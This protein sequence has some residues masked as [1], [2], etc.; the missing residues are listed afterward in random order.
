[1]FELTL[2]GHFFLNRCE[3]WQPSPLTYCDAFLKIYL[4]T[5]FSMY[6]IFLET[7]ETKETLLD[8]G[9]I[10]IFRGWIWLEKC[11]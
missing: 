2:Q 6:M 4:K 10:L 7:E 3:I 5:N 1:M 11:L 8:P 9:Y